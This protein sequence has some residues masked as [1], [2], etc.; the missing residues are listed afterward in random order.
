MEPRW[1]LGLNNSAVVPTGAHRKRSGELSGQSVSGPDA[2]GSVGRGSGRVDGPHV[3]VGGR[4]TVKRGRQARIH[5]S[6]VTLTDWH[7]TGAHVGAFKNNVSE[8][9][10]LVKAAIKIFKQPALNIRIFASLNHF[11]RV[12]PGIIHALK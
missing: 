5:I 1:P 12:K 2:G 8:F 10:C 3:R 6:H 9:T 11:L 7:S 4:G